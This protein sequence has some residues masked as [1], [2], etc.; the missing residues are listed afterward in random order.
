MKTYL[1]IAIIILLALLAG[2]KEKETEKAIYLMLE[3]SP[4][5]SASVKEMLEKNPQV[6]ESV[7]GDKYRDP[8]SL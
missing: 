6:A 7:L 3:G 8:W 2:C 4:E 1:R 5:V